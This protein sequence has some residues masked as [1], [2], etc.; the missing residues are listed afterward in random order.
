MI[1]TNYVHIYSRTQL[2]VPF[3]CLTSVWERKNDMTH[4]LA[5]LRSIRLPNA[6][7]GC[8]R[9]CTCVMDHGAQV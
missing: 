1:L 9:H 6:N 4:K 7:T 2:G 8:R 5:S 3:A